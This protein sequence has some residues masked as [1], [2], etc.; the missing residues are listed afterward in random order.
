M[1][2]IGA[3]A[4]RRLRLCR[5]DHNEAASPGHGRQP[6]EQLFQRPGVTMAEN[7]AIAATQAGQQWAWIGPPVLVRNQE[8]PGQVPPLLMKSL[9]RQ[10]E[11]VRVWR[12]RTGARFSVS[13]PV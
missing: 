7:D 2:S 12:S 5:Q 3:K 1:A 4:R 6:L 8:K 10:P 13:P 9:I 11:P